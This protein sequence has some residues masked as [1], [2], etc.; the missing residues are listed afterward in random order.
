[1]L[2]SAC[3]LSAPAATSVLAAPT[4][5][6]AG[7]SV[8]SAPA[9]LDQ[10]A[11]E[12]LAA[13]E[14]APADAA[15][16]LAATV[17]LFQAADLRLQQGT[18]DVL[19]AAAASSLD[20]VLAAEDRVSDDVRTAVLSLCTAGLQAAER[21]LAV[22]PDD[23]GARLHRALHLSLIAWANGPLRS[24]MAGY[25]GKLVAAIDA[26]VAADP[27]FDH[28]AP[29][30]LQ[31]RFRGKAPWPYGDLPLAQRALGRAVERAP[32]VVNHLFAG[33]VAWAAGQ[34]ERAVASWRAATTAD[35]DA[36]TR[37]S[38]ALLQELARRRLAAIAP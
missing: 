1:M 25:G 17:L 4:P 28:A 13:S 19:A 24:V 31:G 15:A 30:R 38:A 33:D 16:A 27:D 5:G 35:S 21:A 11:R 10:L 18:V 12:A 23:Q 9:E 3:A 34:R 29:L 20:E 2:A 22:R 32:I 7:P 36:S 8:A 14:R 6:E 26:A 37:W